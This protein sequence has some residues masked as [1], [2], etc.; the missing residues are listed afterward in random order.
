MEGD[1]FGGE[2]PLDRLTKS[3]PSE[4]PRPLRVLGR[5]ITWSARAVVSQTISLF[6]L[7]QH[8]L[9]MPLPCAPFH[10]NILKEQLGARD[11]AMTATSTDDTE[12]DVEGVCEDGR[13]IDSRI[14]ATELSYCVRCDSTYCRY[15]MRKRREEVER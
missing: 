6:A 8:H 7:I 4:R 5:Y 15:E 9:S 14:Q 2:A 10:S 1:V 13:C 12:R 3:S 11:A